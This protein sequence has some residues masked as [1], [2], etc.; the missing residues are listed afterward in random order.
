MKAKTKRLFYFSMTFVLLTTLFLCCRSVLSLGVAAYGWLEHVRSFLF[1]ASGILAEVM[2]A[3]GIIFNVLIGFSIRIGDTGGRE[4]ERPSP[5]AY[6]LLIA[7]TG[8]YV[9]S[10]P[11]FQANVMGAH[12]WYPSLTTLGIAAGTAS[13]LILIVR[14]L[15]TKNELP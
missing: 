14:L 1:E 5:I 6:A 12:A 13:L 7:T 10:S 15:P 3:F 2:I 4:V 11:H 8:A 9:A